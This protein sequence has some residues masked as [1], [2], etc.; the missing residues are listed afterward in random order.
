MGITMSRVRGK[1]FLICHSIVHD[2]IGSTIVTLDLSTALQEA[3]AEVLVYATFIGDPAMSLFEERSIRVVDD[4]AMTEV[5]FA[6]FD[7][8]WVNSQVLPEVMVD[9][10]RAP[11]PEP[12]PSFVFLHM[13]AIHFAPDEHPYID[14][15]EERLSSLS[16]FISPETRR[17]L[18]PYFDGEM[19][20]EVYPNPTPTAF[21]QSVHRP[22]AAPQQV[23]IV[24]NHA[25]PELM[26]AKDLLVERGLRVRHVGS[27]GEGQTL[28]TPEVLAEADVVVSIGKTVQY[29]LVSGRPVYV[30]DRFGGYGYLDDDQLEHAARRNFSG[31]GGRELTAEQIVQEIVD[32][33]PA[34]VEFHARRR[35]EFVD[36]YSIDRVLPRVLEALEPRAIEPLTTSQHL[37]LRS[38]QAFGARF[39]HYWGHN[40]NEVRNREALTRDLEAARAETAAA[41][42]DLAAAHREADSLRAEIDRIHG[43]WTFRTGSAIV[44]PASLAKRAV[45]RR[46]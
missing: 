3:G 30:H 26:R 38:A 13:S 4:A 1:R 24:S 42:A 16:L 44:R 20:T 11:L 15:M 12:M 41:R 8:V 18:L 28:V 19:A 45:R 14:H 31:R 17:R 2:L 25:E 5:S 29:C 21:S 6:D 9:Q 33:F 34:A 23:L 46:P 32:G 35:D 36:T 37:A 7:H 27:T 22:K 39:F 10:L 40:A 43:S